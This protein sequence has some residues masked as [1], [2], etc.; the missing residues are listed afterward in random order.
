MRTAINFEAKDYPLKDVLFA[1]WRY[2]IPRYQRPYTWEE[3]QI[4]EF[5]NDLVA[6][7]M[8]VFLGSFILNNEPASKGY[9][10]VIDGQQRMLTVTIFMAV[11]RDLAQNLD[12][13]LAGLIQDFDIAYKDRDGKYHF[14]ITCGESTQTYFQ[15]CIQTNNVNPSQ[16]KPQTNEEARIQFAYEYLRKMVETEL[17]LRANDSDK[18]ARLKELRNQV[19]NLI[20]IRIDIDSE[21]DAYEIFETTNA[22]G[23]DLSVGDLVKNLIFKHVQINNDKGD[24]AKQIWGEI[25][26]NIEDAASEMKRFIRY[27]WISKNAHVHDKQLFKTIKRKTLKWDE[28]LANL[29]TASQHYSQLLAGN[30][31]LWPDMNHSS[32]IFRS[33][34]ALRFMGVVQCHVLF[35]CILRN[36]SKLGTD[37]AKMFELIE[38]FSFMYSVVC[39]MPSNK[40]EKVYSRYANEIERI[41]TTEQAKRVSGAIQ[42]TFEEIRKIMV[43]LKPS[44]E[45]F[46]DGFLGISYSSSQ[47]SRE[48]LKYILE[49]IERHLTTGEKEIDFEVVN[50]EHILPQA[51][52]KE[53]GLSKKQIKSYVNRLGNLTLV[54]K[55]FNSAAGNKSLEAKVKELEGTDLITTRNL[56]DQIKKNNFKW[57][58][59]EISQRQ[60]QLAKIAYDEV[61][62]F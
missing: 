8:P 33:V 60:E 49:K 25:I 54:H 31:E 7:D 28:L 9:I 20:V 36:Y 13:G 55:K 23:V 56:L 6:E 15:N 46:R 45:V 14:R 47:R 41:I 27:Y 34:C 22:R 5:W 52:S 10:E 38:N 1:S 30:K 44:F 40:I 53:W 3:D 35:L 42:R 19:S 24:F 51:P 37:P 18:V 16:C 4:A 2:V 12:K 21:E 11:L 39:R 32:A 17:Q 61:W 57:G 29:W 48:L 43:D 58:E 26:G 59:D 62:K 50:I